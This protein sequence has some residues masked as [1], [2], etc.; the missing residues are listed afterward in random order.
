[1]VSDP[2]PEVS[3]E[4]DEGTSR[5]FPLPQI[6]DSPPPELRYRRALRLGA[7]VRALWRSRHIIGGL[8][9]RQVRSQY[10]QQVLGLAWAVLT[11]FAQMLV[12]T[13]LLNRVGGGKAV[14]TGGVWTPLFLYLGLTAW[15]F[16]SSSVSSGGASLVGNPLLN[17][18][19]APREVFP[20]S[21]VA[22]SGIDALASTLML[23][24]LFLADG[25]W[26]SATFYWAPLMLVILLGFAVAISL[27]V[28][29][30]TVYVRDLRSGL[31][32]L[33]QLGL[34]LTPVLYPV[35][36]IPA[37]ARVAYM[38]VNPV[39]AVIDGLRRCLF[40][41]RAPNATY[42]AVAA[43]STAVYLVV[44]FMVFKRLETGFAD[45]S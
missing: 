36:E 25:R 24:L 17:K 40:Y 37:D 32:L 29:A 43:A 45:V 23:P 2:A 22:S 39:G 11:P 44:A 10:S 41:D 13:F 3:A 31:P 15:S 14:D 20:L 28:S 19:Y 5:S 34:F 6:A 30:I 4:L 7:A 9:V 38:A 12:F 35:T 21:Q 42:T 1:M 18:V 33:L 8:V 26:P 16:F 27:F